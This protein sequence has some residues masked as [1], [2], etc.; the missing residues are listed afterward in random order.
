MG[1]AT[2]H[3]GATSGDSSRQFRIQNR[4]GRLLIDQAEKTRRHHHE[5]RLAAEARCLK[6]KQPSSFPRLLNALLIRQSKPWEQAQW[7]R[8]C[9]RR[10]RRTRAESAGGWK[11]V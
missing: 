4:A 5:E 3:A 10:W 11:G 1:A 9:S 2:R 8:K 7:I 6:E